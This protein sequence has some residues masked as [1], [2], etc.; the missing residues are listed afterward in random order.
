LRGWARSRGLWYYLAAS[1][2]TPVLAVLLEGVD[3]AVPN[4]RAGGTNTFP[5]AYVL[6]ILPSMIW[7]VLLERSKFA[8]D[9]VSLRGGRVALLDYAS[10]LLPVVIGGS[11]LIV[12]G[13]P[14]AQAAGRNEILF[15]CIGLIAMALVYNYVSFLAAV[16][17]ILAAALAGFGYGQEAPDGWAV[18]LGRWVEGPGIAQ[19]IVAFVLSTGFLAARSKK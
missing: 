6:A 18:V 7:P 11:I 16:I 8:I 13:S 3:I 9:G 12:A 2:L 15:T 4:I 5:L 10:T 19:L 14:V 17:Y 1:A